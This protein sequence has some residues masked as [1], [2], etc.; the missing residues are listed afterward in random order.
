[1]P[2]ERG[3]SKAVIERNTRRLIREGYPPRQASAI[4]HRKA[5]DYRK[6]RRKKR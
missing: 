4:A 5:G 3:K 1:M 2:M 6:P